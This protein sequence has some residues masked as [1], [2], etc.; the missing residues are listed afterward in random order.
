M[1]VKLSYST[2]RLAAVFTLTY[3]ALFA[4]IMFLAAKESDTPAL[5]WILLINMSIMFTYGVYRFIK[6][7]TYVNY[8]A[9][10]NNPFDNV[11]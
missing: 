3:R 11:N 7:L 1:E 6:M 10:T 8:L 9:K 5:K 2:M 4:T